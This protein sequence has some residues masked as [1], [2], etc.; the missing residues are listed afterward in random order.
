MPLD[1]A[2]FAFFAE[3]VIMKINGE[4]IACPVSEHET[5]ND[6]DMFHVMRCLPPR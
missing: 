2:A 3:K 6:N 5:K 4:L 1:L